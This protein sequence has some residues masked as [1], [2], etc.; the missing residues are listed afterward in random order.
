MKTHAGVLVSGATPVW[1]LSVMVPASSWCGGSGLPNDVP[2]VLVRTEPTSWAAWEEVNPAGAEPEVTI[3]APRSALNGSATD[4]DPTSVGVTARTAAVRLT[5]GAALL[6]SGEQ[7]DATAPSASTATIPQSRSRRIRGAAAC[8][9]ISVIVGGAV[10]ALPADL[11]G[12]RALNMAGATKS[13]LRPPSCPPQAE[14]AL[15]WS[16]AIL[17]SIDTVGWCSQ[18]RVSDSGSSPIRV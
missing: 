14:G 9:C 4:K 17:V 2:K 16:V 5:G 15:T 10:P 3:R 8:C 11:T 12:V 7:P 1:P 13:E 6:V 18:S